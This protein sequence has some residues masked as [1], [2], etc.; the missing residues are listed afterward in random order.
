[1]DT[2]KYPRTPYIADVPLTNFVGKDIVISE[3]LD[4]SNTLL[5]NGEV[6]GR[7]ASL[8]SHDGWRAMVRKHH[9]WRTHSWM[10]YIY[11]ED[12]YGVHSIEYDAVPEEKTFY[13]FA[14]REILPELNID[15]FYNEAMV[16]SYA[17]TLGMPYVPVL[18]RGRV[19]SEN[20]LTALLLKYMMGDSELGGEREGV[21]IRLKDEFGA[22][23]FGK[24]MAKVVR[25]NHVKSNEHWTKN[26]QPCKIRRQ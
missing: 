21:V 3:K 20:E 22:E 26:W 2:P 6:Y 23:D 11:G 8:P 14:V 7:G 17:R 9:A 18:Y 10:C 19:D 15:L 25:P 5:F 13:I 1:M 16:R 12:I 24:S 4:G